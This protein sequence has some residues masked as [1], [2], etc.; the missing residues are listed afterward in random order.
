[1]GDK[2]LE[3][4]I[5]ERVRQNPGCMNNPSELFTYSND[6]LLLVLG[7]MNIAFREIRYVNDYGFSLYRKNADEPIYESEADTS[8]NIEKNDDSVSF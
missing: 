8:M 1:S 5:E 7:G 3:Y 4:P 2:V 6:S